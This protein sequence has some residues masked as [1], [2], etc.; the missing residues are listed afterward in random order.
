M[1]QVIKSRE[2]AIR[3][4]VSKQSPETFNPLDRWKRVTSSD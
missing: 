2:K 3:G 1:M 4:V